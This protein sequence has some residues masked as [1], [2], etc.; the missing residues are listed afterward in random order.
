MPT[1]LFVLVNAII[2]SVRLVDIFVMT[3]RAQQRDVLLLFTST[4]WASTWDTG[5]GGAHDRIA[6]VPGRGGHRAVRVWTR[7]CTTSEEADR[8]RVDPIPRSSAALRV[9]DRGPPEFSTRF[10]ILA[11]LSLDNFRRAW[12]RFFRALFPQ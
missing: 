6:G 11:P 5:Y 9:L 10:E 1:T 7:R 12:R 4:R 2:N 3:R 8:R